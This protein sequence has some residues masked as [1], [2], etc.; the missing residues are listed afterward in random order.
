MLLFG[1]SPL[2]D[3]IKGIVSMQGVFKV[4]IHAIWIEQGAWTINTRNSQTM[5]KH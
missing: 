1:Y 4:E 3:N 2:L 5:V